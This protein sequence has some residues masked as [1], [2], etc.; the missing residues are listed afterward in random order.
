MWQLLGGLDMN[1]AM[2]LRLYRN[3]IAQKGTMR[4]DGPNFT[5]Y[6]SARR[7]LLERQLKAFNLLRHLDVTPSP[8]GIKPYRRLWVMEAAHPPLTDYFVALAG[9]RR[10]SKIELIR[11]FGATVGM[12]HS[13]RNAGTGD[14]LQPESIPVAKK[15]LGKVQIYRVL[16]AQRGQSNSVC[17]DGLSEAITGLW[18]AAGGILAGNWNGFPSVAVW[19][20]GLLI[21]DLS[22]ADYWEPLFDLASFRPEAIGLDRLFFWE[23]FLQGY[24]ATCEFPEREKEKIETVYRYNYLQ[25]LAVGKGASHAE[26]DLR[27]QWWRKV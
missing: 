10:R 22:R 23:Y 14:L 5:L 20:N 15:M 9:S 21:M 16:L 1:L 27:S 8:G 4:W 2:E 26:E 11:R 19:D 7:C 17:W 25:A 13:L 6:A 24:G 3:H 12:V 18:G